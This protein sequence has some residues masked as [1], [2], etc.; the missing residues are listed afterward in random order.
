MNSDEVEMARVDIVDII[1]FF[2]KERVVYDP[3]VRA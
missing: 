1:F 3:Y 2:E